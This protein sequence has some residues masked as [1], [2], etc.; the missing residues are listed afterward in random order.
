MDGFANPAE[1]K[2]ARSYY[3][4]NCEIKDSNQ[5]IRDS[6]GPIELFEAYNPK[7]KCT[8]YI[9]PEFGTN[10]VELRAAAEIAFWMGHKTEQPIRT[11]AIYKC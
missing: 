10:I 3:L 7:T 11:E 1:I 8:L 9:I 4:Q 5:F 6:K 2:A